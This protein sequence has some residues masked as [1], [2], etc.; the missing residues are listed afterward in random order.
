MGRGVKIV[1][2]GERERERHRERERERERERR[3]ALSTRREIWEQNG[4]RRERG[5]GKGQRGSR[6]ARATE[7][8]GGANSPFY[9]ESGITG[10]CQVIVG[11]SLNKML[12]NTNLN[13]GEILINLKNVSK[14]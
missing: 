11:W 2:E 4:M 12:T 3:S 13:V 10:C 6:K 1:L 7:K 8:G 14:S 5:G 9:S